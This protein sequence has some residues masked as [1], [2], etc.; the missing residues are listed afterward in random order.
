MLF[1][2]AIDRHFN[3]ES[4]LY[5]ELIERLCQDEKFEDS[6]G[7]LNMMINRGYVINP[8]LFMLMIDGLNH[9]GNKYRAS[10]RR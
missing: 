8:A 5:N 1:K 4:F 9:E 10:K 7:I 2:V 3:L 6:S